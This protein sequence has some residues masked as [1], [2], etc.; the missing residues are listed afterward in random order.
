MDKKELRWRAW[1]NDSRNILAWLK[2]ISSILPEF[3]ELLGNPLP[4][5]VY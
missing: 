1:E 5:S 4:Q 2:E 3:R